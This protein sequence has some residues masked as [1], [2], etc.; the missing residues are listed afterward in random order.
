M[1]YDDSETEYHLTP[2]GWITGDAPIG[3]VETWVRSASQQSGLSKE[4]ISWVC[5][6]IDPGVSRAER[7]VLRAKYQ[8]FMGVSGR[9]GDRIT[10]IGKPL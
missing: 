4:Y 1:P 8:A 2:R 5:K 6:W 10:T 9:S 3:R 7:D